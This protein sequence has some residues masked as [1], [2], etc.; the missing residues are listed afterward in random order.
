[1]IAPELSYPWLTIPICAVIA[2]NMHMHYYY[3]CTVPPGFVDDGT[4]VEG[5][6][7]LWARRKAQRPLTGVRWTSPVLITPALTRTC[8]KCGKVKPEVRI[9]FLRTR[10]SHGRRASCEKL[11]V[12]SGEDASLSDMQSL[13]VEV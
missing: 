1:M 9:L 7:L 5:K 11:M 12:D 2:L 10:V 8:L 6:G 4:R 3:V 13:R